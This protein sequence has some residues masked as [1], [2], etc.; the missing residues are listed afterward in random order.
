MLRQLHEAQVR[1]EVKSKADAREFVRRNSLSP[2]L[3]PELEAE[4][5]E[6]AG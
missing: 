6:R 1:G 5:R 4:G 3:G 2:P